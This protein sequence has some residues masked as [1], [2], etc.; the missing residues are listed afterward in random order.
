MAKIR[1][2]WDIELDSGEMLRVVSDQRDYARW[3]VQPFHD[4]ELLHVKARFLAWS[5]AFREGRYKGG[6]E[7]FNERDCVEVGVVDDG[8]GEQGLDPG[9]PDTGGG[10]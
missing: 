9:R 3:E 2:E 1:T 6:W 5:A 4:N 10:S 8:E 7:K